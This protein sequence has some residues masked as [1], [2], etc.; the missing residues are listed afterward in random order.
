MFIIY[1]HLKDIFCNFIKKKKNSTQPHM[2]HKQYLA[3]IAKYIK[4]NDFNFIS[5]F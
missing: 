5:N 3:Q 4:N 2:N 1:N